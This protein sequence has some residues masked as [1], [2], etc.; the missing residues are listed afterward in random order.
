[1]TLNWQ[2]CVAD[3]VAAEIET[4]KVVVRAQKAVAAV[5]AVEI[6]VATAA[7]IVRNPE[8]APFLSK[9]LTK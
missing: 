2:G 6:A 1:M 4:V 7:E 9:T 8:F 5:V 3:V